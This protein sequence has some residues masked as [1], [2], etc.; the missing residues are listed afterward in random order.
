MSIIRILK[1]TSTRRISER[2]LVGA[3]KR[4]GNRR[5]KGYLIGAVA[6]L[7]V[8]FGPMVATG[9]SAG[10]STVGSMSLGSLATANYSWSQSNWTGTVSVSGTLYSGTRSCIEVRVQ[11]FNRLWGWG[12]W[13]TIG[14]SCNGNTL[15]FSGSVSDVYSTHVN[16]QIYISSGL[17]HGVSLK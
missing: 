9:P 16:L 17:S 4:V 3:P 14:E 8:T 7:A 5:L 12:G 15:W 10:A 13:T 11:G 1:S 2:Y 6:A